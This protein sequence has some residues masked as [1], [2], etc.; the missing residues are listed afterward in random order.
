MPLPRGTSERYVRPFFNRVTAASNVTPLLTI[1]STVCA[2]ASGELAFQNCWKAWSIPD[3]A[4]ITSYEVKAARSVA[5]KQTHK[6][7]CALCVPCGNVSDRFKHHHRVIVR[8]HRVRIDCRSREQRV[9][10][11]P[12]DLKITRFDGCL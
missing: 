6:W 1:A 2:A 11:R 4:A 8:L 9:A 7:L 12:V 5:S 3:G 10:L